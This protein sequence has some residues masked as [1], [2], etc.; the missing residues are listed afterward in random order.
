MADQRYRF[1]GPI[2][3][4]VQRLRDRRRFRD[5]SLYARMKRGIQDRLEAERAAKQSPLCTRSAFLSEPAP[6]P[7]AGF[8]PAA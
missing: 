4:S 3:E 6:S 7:P 1:G 8:P 2:P 5:S